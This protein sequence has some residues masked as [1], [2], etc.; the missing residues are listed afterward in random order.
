MALMILLFA[1]MTVVTAADALLMRLWKGPGSQARMPVVL[2][3]LVAAWVLATNALAYEDMLSSG[4]W[5][6][7]I[8]A[9]AAV[10]LKAIALSMMTYVAA[11]VFVRAR[12]MGGHPTRWAL[13]AVL[14][15]LCFYAV[16][17]DMQFMRMSARER[18][19][20]SPM[21][22]DAQIERIANRV[23]DGRAYDSEI[24]AFLAN[25]L[26]PPELLAQFATHPDP[27]MRAAVA[28]NNA[29]SARL[30]AVLAADPEARVRDAA[31]S[32]SA[33]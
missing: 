28:Q 19:A 4:A 21:L 7:A 17:V 14:A 1:W 15:V 11:R 25:P 5:T 22:E 18:Y 8:L 29:I 2:T 6:G 27:L 16:S 26:C 24:R 32:W 30:A 9:I 3:L 31:N 33:N 13:P 20:A 12:I 10:P 23:R